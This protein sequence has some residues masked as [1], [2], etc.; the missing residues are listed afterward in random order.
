MISCTEFIPSYSELFSYLEERDGKQAITKFWSFLFEPT[1]DKIPLINFL[2]KERIRGCFSYWK[3]TLSEEASDVNIYL[4]EKAGWFMCEMYHCPSKGR[5]LRLKDEIGIEPYPDYCLHCDYYRAAV[6]KV[7]LNYIWNFNGVDHAACSWL[8]TDPKVFDGRIIVDDNTEILE[9]RAAEREYFHPDFHSSMN[10]GIDYVG[11]TYGVEAI[12]EYLTRFTKNVY[13]PTMKA[14]KEKGLLALEEKILDTYEKEKASD[15][16]KTVLTENT[17][18]VDVAYCPAV[19]HLRA[20]GREVTP[21]FGYT[22][23]VV[24]DV[25]AEAGGFTFNMECYEEETGR[26]RYTFTK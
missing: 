15:A 23:K 14:I 18:T 2:K 3:G 5:L 9:V 10:S 13:H 21:W 26:A 25:L 20:T 4:N 16:V 1:G 12:E 24:M 22:T 8:I 11:R 6:E 7:G 17:L 19:K